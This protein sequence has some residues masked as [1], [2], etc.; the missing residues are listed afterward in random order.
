[1]VAKRQSPKQRTKDRQAKAKKEYDRLVKK[2]KPKVS[3]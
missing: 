2:I 1:M 3:M